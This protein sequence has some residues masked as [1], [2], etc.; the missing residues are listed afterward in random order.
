M[1]D[2][3]SCNVVNTMRLNKGTIMTKR[4]CDMKI[5]KHSTMTRTKRLSMNRSRPSRILV[6]PMDYSM[7]LFS[8]W[9]YRH[10]SSKSLKM[11]CLKNRSLMKGDWNS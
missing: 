5:T 3:S 1:E 6:S 4:Q 10:S 8:I 7:P 11:K 9:L 2:G